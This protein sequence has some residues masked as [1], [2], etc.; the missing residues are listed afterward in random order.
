MKRRT[1]EQLRL[2]GWSEEAILDLHPTDAHREARG[3]SPLPRLNAHPTDAHREARETV[4]YEF[5]HFE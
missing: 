1:N 4:H 2:D 3:D 5:I